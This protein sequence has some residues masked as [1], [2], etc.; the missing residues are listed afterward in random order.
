MK[1]LQQQFEALLDT[2][3][4]DPAAVDYSLLDR[5][6]EQLAQLARMTNS[7][8][9]VFDSCR[10]RHAYVSY[11][12]ADLFRYDMKGIAE[13][14]TEYFARHIHPDDFAPLFRNNLA[15]MRYVL[16][17]P[18]LIPDC[19]L[20]SE[21][22]VEAE[23]R[24]TRVIEQ[25]QVLELDANGNVWLSFSMLDISPNQNAFGGVRSRLVNFRTGEVLPFQPDE[26]DCDALSGRE[27]EILRMI[28]RGK[29]SKEIAEE[30]SISV[31][32]VNTHR[33]RILEKLNVDNSM[34]AVRYAD[35]HGLLD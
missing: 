31:H 21:Y 12:F 26:A 34:E 15:C 27:T 22:R 29:L 6:V 14:D 11:N 23:G 13:E 4:I 30:L 8:V 17:H 1:S 25:F 35:A 28:G 16:A 33:Q 19:K 5:H 20:I 9:T 18:E 2:Q 7:G 32:T 10:R 3:R 24:C